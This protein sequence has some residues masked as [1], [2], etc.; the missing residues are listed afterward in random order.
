MAD[1]F[2]RLLRYLQFTGLSCLFVSFFTDAPRAVVTVY[3]GDLSK[4]AHRDGW[5]DARFGA[6]IWVS[7]AIFV[8]ATLGVH[9]FA[10]FDTQDTNAKGVSKNACDW[11]SHPEGIRRPVSTAGASVTISKLLGLS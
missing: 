5:R 4:N 9:R 1:W 10:K 8:V 11:D 3:G 7:A 2:S 6:P